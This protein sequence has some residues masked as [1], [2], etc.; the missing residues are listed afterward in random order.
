MRL[1]AGMKAMFGVWR[2]WRQ[3]SDFVRR[4]DRLRSILTSL[5]QCSP[6]A[7]SRAHR[8]LLVA[9]VYV[10]GPVA[11]AQVSVTQSGCAG[12]QTGCGSS[13]AAAGRAAQPEAALAQAKSL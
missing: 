8:A 2:K 4:S 9:T 3:G 7:H 6:T 1:P 12:R 10:L 11:V 13:S 5:C